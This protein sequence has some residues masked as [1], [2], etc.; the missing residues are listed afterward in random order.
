MTALLSALAGL[1]AS[2]PL[3]IAFAFLVVA[4]ALASLGLS[5]LTT[6]RAIADTPQSRVRSAAQGHVELLGRARWLPGPPIRSPLSG[7]SCVWWHYRVVRNADRRTEVIADETSDDLFL[8]SDTSGDCIVDPVGAQVEPSL[9]RS[10]RGRGEQPG[11]IPQPGWDAW[12][13]F[14][15]YRYSE[16]LLRVDDLLIARGWFRTQAALAEADER[17]DLAALLADWKRDRRELLRR[18]DSNRDG[19]ID[20]QEWEAARAA[21]LEVVREQRASDAA[22][23]DLN[24]LSKPADRRDFVLAACTRSGLIARFKH[25]GWRLIGLAAGAATIGLA[26]LRARG[27]I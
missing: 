19:Q 14:G 26:A 8:L 12:F 15:E 3:P 10:W 9:A 17:R 5:R 16:R 1:L 7:T 18:F 4:V 2:L 24:V 25:Q 21:A 27:L 11:R 20:A 13:T 22:A 6:A 23:P